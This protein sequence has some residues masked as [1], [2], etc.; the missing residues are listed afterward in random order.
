MTMAPTSS[1]SGNRRGSSQAITWSMHILS[2]A[3]LVAQWNLM[4]RA[5]TVASMKLSHWSWVNDHIA[6][7][8]PAIYTKTDKDSMN[9]V[10]KSIYSNPLQPQIDAFLAFAVVIFCRQ[11]TPSGLSFNPPVFDGD[12]Q[13][14]RLIF[15]LN[16]IMQYA[17]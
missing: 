2:W 14:I 4:S 16:V 7:V 1:T 9:V 6:I 5:V 12:H 17:T 8:T 15:E 10:P 11:Y 13:E 3:F